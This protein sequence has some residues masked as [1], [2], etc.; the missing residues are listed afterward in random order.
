LIRKLDSHTY[1]NE[2]LKYIFDFQYFREVITFIFLLAQLEKG[3]QIGKRDPV[4]A[5]NITANAKS[6]TATLTTIAAPTTIGPPFRR[7]RPRTSRR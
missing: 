2:F 6:A 3:I 4:K 5:A 7:P 1:A